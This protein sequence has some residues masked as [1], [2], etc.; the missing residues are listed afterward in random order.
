MLLTLFILSG[1]VLGYTLCLYPAMAW[2]LARTK[3]KPPRVSA[4]DDTLPRISVIIPV[5][6]EERIL[7][8]KVENCL[9]SDYPADRVEFVFALD[10]C[11]DGSESALSVFKDSRIQVRVFR[12]NRGKVA[13]LNDVIPALGGDIVVL[14]DASGMVNPGG[15]RALIRPFADPD[16]GGVAGV[17]R[18]HRDDRSELDSAEHSYHGFEMKLRSWEGLIRTTL[19]GTGSLFAFRKFD[20]E[21]FPEGLFNEDYYLPARLAI[22]G[23]R[24]VYTPEAQLSDH[25]S[26][27]LPV[28]FRRRV[29]IAYGNWQQIRYLPELLN[30]SRGYLFWVFV[31]HKLLRMLMPFV[32]ILF[33]L[34]GAALGP[35]I[36][37]V[38]VAAAVAL[39]VAGGLGLLLD[40]YFRNFNPLSVIALIML[41]FLAVFVGTGKF[42]AGRKTKW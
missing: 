3:G 22:R 28:V 34:S 23:K 15:L 19:S 9:E 41:N 10:G 29:R 35:I 30:P 39:A 32:M 31:S 16:V 33:V 5:Y 2:W 8:R 24:V 7:S 18:V 20:Y 4:D 42:L 21:P 6:N 13:V 25:V 27:Q 11:T 36:F 37:R 40:R 14:S 26:T 38:V 1:A 12:E 17:Y